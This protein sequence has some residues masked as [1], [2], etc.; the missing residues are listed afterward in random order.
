MKLEAG[1][2]YWNRRGE[3]VG[4]IVGPM[5]TLDHP[6]YKFKV[7]GGASYT[8]NGYFWR[9]EQKADD[10]LIAPW[11]EPEA[12]DLPGQ[13][14]LKEAHPLMMIDTERLTKRE[15]FAL[16]A[17]AALLQLDA[18]LDEVAHK[19]VYLADVM[20]EKLKGKT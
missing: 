4:P 10:D 8:E 5:V 15:R 17:M 20:L 7:N 3:K 9:G 19:A 13:L 6:D 11:E 14:K 12:K 18:N 2:Y 1:K 16:A